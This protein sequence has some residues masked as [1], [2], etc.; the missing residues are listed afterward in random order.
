[1]K[2]SDI[3]ISPLNVRNGEYVEETVADLA[4]NIQENGLFSKL[5]L[6]KVGKG[7]GKYEVIAGGRRHLALIK[8]YGEDYELPESDYIIKDEDDFSAIVD[9]ITENVHRI[10][11]SPIQMSEAAN[12]LRAAKKGISIKE[13]AKIMWAP[14]AKIKRV[15]VLKEDLEYI[16]ESAKRELALSDEEEPRFT[17]AHWD[18]VKKSGLNLSDADKIQ[19]VCD[20]I[21][22]NDVPASRVA[23]AVSRF[24]PKETPAE[25]N[26][27][28]EPE[29]PPADPSKIGE[30]V[31]VGILDITPEGLVNVIDK[32]GILKPFD[33]QYYVDYAKQ[34]NF[35]VSIKAKFLIKSV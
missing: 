28:P 26:M 25:G 13:I 19:D 10:G 15:L 8:A 34:S 2:L 31:F 32:A 16:P 18:A 30:D 22:N 9:S 5:L 33:L 23:D 29:A 35:K 20:F 24:L 14:E 21:M 27:G 11:L 6:R 12:M 1:M 3:K 4:E 7:D 17:D